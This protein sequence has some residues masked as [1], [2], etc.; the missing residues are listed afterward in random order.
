MIQLTPLT[1]WLNLTN[2]INETRYYYNVT[3]ND[4]TGN[5]NIS[6]T[7][8]FLV[9]EFVFHPPTP[10]PPIFIFTGLTT[11]EVSESINN[12]IIYLIIILGLFIYLFNLG[13]K[14]K[15]YIVT[16]FSGIWLV[17][18]SI[19]LSTETFVYKSFNTVNS[20]LS[21]NNSVGNFSFYNSTNVRYIVKRTIEIDTFNSVLW[22][23]FLSMGLF[24]ILRSILIKYGSD[25]NI[26]GD[27][28]N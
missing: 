28:R 5:I 24:I 22:L 11:T 15:S 2:L 26:N 12:S 8:N 14:S 6:L 9:N 10:S 16:L 27:D 1:F 18:L 3:G 17:L 21:I 4:S 20:V 7:R 13:V 23:V 25:N 19:V